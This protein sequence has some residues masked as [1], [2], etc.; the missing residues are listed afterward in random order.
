MENTFLTDFDYIL[1]TNDNRYVAKQVIKGSHYTEHIGFALGYNTLEHAKNV[2]DRVNE[3]NEKDGVP[4]RITGIIKRE[5][6]YTKV[7]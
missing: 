5:I 3:K 4:V 7:V 2:A 6:T 1:A